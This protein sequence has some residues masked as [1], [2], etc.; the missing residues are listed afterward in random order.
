MPIVRRESP[1][2]SRVRAPWR[3]AGQRLPGRVSPRPRRPPTRG[4]AAWRCGP[5]RTGSCG[6]SDR[7]LCSQLGNAGRIE[8]ELFAVEFVVVLAEPSPREADRSRTLGQAEHD[9]LHL[10]RAQVLVLARRDRVERPD[11]WVTDQLL[12]VVDRCD[13]RAGQFEGRPY[14]LAC[15]CA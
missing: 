15:A 14:F 7:S 9:V 4:A 6:A 8:A 3:P 12:D 2:P 5:G 13:R 10:E 11:L 1:R